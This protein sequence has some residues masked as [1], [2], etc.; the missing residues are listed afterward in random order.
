MRISKRGNKSI[1]YSNTQESLIEHYKLAKPTLQSIF[2]SELVLKSMFAIREGEKDIQ[3]IHD[4]VYPD[5]PAKDKPAKR[6]AVYGAVNTLIRYRIVNKS[7]AGFVL[8]E[9]GEVVSGQIYSLIK[10][11]GLFRRYRDFW[12]EHELKYIPPL[13]LSKF[14]KL[15]DISLIYDPS[16][17]YLSRKLTIQGIRAAE[18][19]IYALTSAIEPE[20]SIEYLKKVEQG[21]EAR[22]LINKDM[23]HQL[24]TKKGFKEKTKKRFSYPNY[25]IRMLELEPIPFAMLLTEKVILIGLYE[26]SSKS[27]DFFKVLSSEGSEAIEWGYELFNYLWERGET[28]TSENWRIIIE[29]G[30]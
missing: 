4:S 28:V 18:E 2:R 20:W 6:P 12:L 23:V 5:V 11:T 8:S 7:E 1:K 22:L 14:H 25:E 21:I 29:Q 10:L 9:I 26:K 13:F 17:P 16:D 19:R 27:L 15:A 3:A 24:M 30:K